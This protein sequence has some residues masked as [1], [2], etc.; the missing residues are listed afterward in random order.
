MT[1]NGLAEL[2]G[3]VLNVKCNSRFKPQHIAEHLLRPR[4]VVES[5]K[6][7]QTKLYAFISDSYMIHKEIYDGSNWKALQSVKIP[8]NEEVYAIVQWQTSLYIFGASK[9]VVCMDIESSEITSVPDIPT[10]HINYA[11]TV[12]NDNIYVMGGKVKI[13]KQNEI[14]L[15]YYDYKPLNAISK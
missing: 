5:G 3:D 4:T 7:S 12:H 13:Q 14:C 2:C 8:I 1:S 15:I 11:V 10:E 9:R 6:T